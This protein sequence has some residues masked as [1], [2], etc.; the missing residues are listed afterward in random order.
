MA[1]KLAWCPHCYENRRGR[2]SHEGHRFRV[3]GVE[4]RVSFMGLV[5]HGQ[6]GASGAGG[7]PLAFDARSGMGRDLFEFL[8]ATTWPGSPGDKR[9][10]GTVNFFLHDGRLK[11]VLNDRDWGR[12][13]FVTLDPTQ[14]IWKALEGFLGDPGTDWRLNQDQGSRKK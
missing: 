5:R 7:A 8:T 2:S 12:S 6:S 11:A 9:T 1:C 10:P 13:A 4:R 14:D 3:A